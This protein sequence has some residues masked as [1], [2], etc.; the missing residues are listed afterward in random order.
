M[1]SRIKQL[2]L[3]KKM[4]L[5][6]QVNKY[7]GKKFTAFELVEV[8]QDFY[9]INFG[10]DFLIQSKFD[11]Y[12]KLLVQSTTSA[13]MCL[14]NPRKSLSKSLEKS[15]RKFSSK[16]KQKRRSRKSQKISSFAVRKRFDSLS[17]LDNINDNED[18]PIATKEDSKIK[19][20]PLMADLNQPENIL[21]N[22][23]NSTFFEENLGIEKTQSFIEWAVRL[24]YNGL[25]VITKHKNND[26]DDNDDQNIQNNFDFSK[27][28]FFFQNYSSL[29]LPVYSYQKDVPIIYGSVFHSLNTLNDPQ[30]RISSFEGQKISKPDFSKFQLS[31]EK[32]KKMLANFAYSSLTSLLSCFTSKYLTHLYMNFTACEDSETEFSFEKNSSIFHFIKTT[33]LHIYS[34]NL[35]LDLFLCHLLI[36]KNVLKYHIS[37]VDRF[38]AELFRFE[39]LEK[40]QKISHF[41]GFLILYLLNELRQSIDLYQEIIHTLILRRKVQII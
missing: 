2:N 10:E 20:F 22:I 1:D 3:E 29:V 37:I 17:S 15:L 4:A 36:T 39:N 31:E 7:L 28:E 21:R 16:E 14:P 32:Y 19:E 38:S 25:S 12:K 40:E 24:V 35:D 13:L 5:V 9:L 8:I 26:F 6:D 11:E 30:N 27:N 41:Q 23:V 34:M 33:F 18:Q